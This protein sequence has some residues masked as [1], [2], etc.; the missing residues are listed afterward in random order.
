M[1]NL[2]PESILET[3]LLKRS[4]KQ[5]K[6]FPDRKRKTMNSERLTFFL[7]FPFSEIFER[8]Q[9]QN[10]PAPALSEKIFSEITSSEEFLSYGEDWDGMG[11]LPVSRDAFQAMTS[12]VKDYAIRL[13]EAGLTQLQFEINAVTDGSIDV[14]WYMPKARLL[15]NFKQTDEG[16]SLYY[17]GAREGERDAIKGQV[18]TDQA[19]EFLVTWMNTVLC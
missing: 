3:L 9:L 13:P 6:H 15:M 14:A 5:F 17:Y 10:R 8:K 19:R 16:I 7:Q 18:E 1:P 2:N 4:I 12:M 11:A